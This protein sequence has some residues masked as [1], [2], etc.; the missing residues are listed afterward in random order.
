L[1]RSLVGQKVVMAVTGL[2]LIVFLIGH[3]VGNLK[4]FLGPA[5]FN[6][7]AVGLRTLG[8]PFFARGQ[9][10]WLFRIV[11]LAALVLHIWSATR[12]TL[13]SWSARPNAYRTLATTHTTWG[14][15]TMRWGGVLLMAYLVYHLLDLT[16]GSANPAFVEGDAYGNLV[17]SFQRAPAALAYIAAMAVVGLHLH[18][19]VWSALQTLGLHT[20]PTDRWRRGVAAGF[21]GLVVAGYVVIPLAVLAGVLR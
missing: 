7:Y 19:G 8:A 4:V 9:L 5:H 12:V 15:R 13:A 20:S 6:E 16:F 3:L 21:A 18:H 1:F 10:L 11:M 2:L 17:A 14:A